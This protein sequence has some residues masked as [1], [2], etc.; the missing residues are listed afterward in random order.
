MPQL[1]NGHFHPNLS[2]LSF[3]THHIINITEFEIVLGSCNKPDWQTSAS[4][5]STSFE[6]SNI[7]V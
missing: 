6:L 4:F 2:N 1:D 7:D 3:T 5:P